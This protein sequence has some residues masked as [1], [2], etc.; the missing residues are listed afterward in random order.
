MLGKLDREIR[1]AGG[2]VSREDIADH[3]TN[4]AWTAWHLV[5]HVWADMKG[6]WKAKVAVAKAADVP[7]GELNPKDFKDFVQLESQCPELAYCKL[8]TNASKHVGADRDT[9]DPEFVIE[10][11]AAASFTSS[12][13]STP[14]GLDW[15]PIYDIGRPVHWAYKIVEGEDFAGEDRTNAVHMF[16]KVRG[17]WANF[18]DRHCIGSG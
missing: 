16:Q 17:Y 12:G 1:R 10:A 3:C 4:A 18:I 13:P 15:L 2:E 7:I 5:D 14:D 6:N 8:I 11:S 9:G